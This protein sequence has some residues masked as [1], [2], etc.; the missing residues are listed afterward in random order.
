MDGLDVLG[1]GEMG[2]E[3]VI[4]NVSPAVAPPVEVDTHRIEL[5]VQSNGPKD[6]Q[7]MIRMLSF[8]FAF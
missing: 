5:S 1:A 2:S 3:V 6:N 7:D 8:A 4:L